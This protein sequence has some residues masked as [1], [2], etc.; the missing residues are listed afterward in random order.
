MATREQIQEYLDIRDNID[1]TVNAVL[2]KTVSIDT[3]PEGEEKNMIILTAVT[4]YKKQKYL[5]E[6]VLY[7]EAIIDYKVT[8]GSDPRAVKI[9]AAKY[10]LVPKLLSIE[11]YNHTQ[12]DPNY[13]FDKDIEGEFITYAQEEALWLRLKLLVQIGFIPCPCRA[14]FLLEFSIRVYEFVIELQKGDCYPL[15]RLH[16]AATIEWI[17]KFEMRHRDEIYNFCSKSCN[18]I[19]SVAPV[20]PVCSTSTSNQ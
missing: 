10:K 15:W 11:I 19:Y 7:K 1:M 9:V 13:E 16:R 18:K 3:I 6:K 5:H 8:F 20:V 2:S 14:C 17:K 12:T 4:V